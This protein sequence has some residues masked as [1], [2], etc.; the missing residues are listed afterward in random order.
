MREPLPPRPGFWDLFTAVHSPGRRWPGALRAAFVLALPGSVALLLGYDVE[1]LLIA[2]GG[3]TVIYGEGHPLRTRW[4]VMSIAAL[5]LV[6]GSVAGAFVGSVVW[7]QGG[8]WWLLLSALFTASVATVGAFV[9][10]ALRLQPPG[11][12]FIVMVT[13]GATMVARLGLNPFEVGAWACVGAASGLALG[14]LPGRAPER[15]AVDTLEKAVADFAAGDPSVAR[16]HQART[17]LSNAWNMLADA[18]VIRAG[19]VVDTSRADLVTRTLKAHRRLAA[20]NTPGHAAEELTDTPNY[21]DL[22][23][24]AIPHTR[25][26][27]SYRLYRS[28]HR[29]SHAT[30]TAAKVFGA[31]LAAGVLGIAVGFDRPDWAVVSALLILQWGPDR[32]PG[33]IRGLHRLLGSLLGIGLFAALHLLDLNLWGLLL[34]LAV[35][36]F[37]AEVFVVRNYVLCVIFT[38]PLALMMGNSLALPLGETVVSRTAEVSLSVIFA[39]ALLWQGR[40]EPAHHALLMQRCRESVT[41]LLGALLAATPDQALAQR[42]DLQYELL[43][44]RHAAQSLAGNHPDIATARWEEHLV[45]QATGY[46]LL[47]RCNAAPDTP[48]PVGDIRAVAERIS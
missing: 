2:A 16:L 20:L 28:L 36:Q 12:F 39:L 30:M 33:T 7:D 44:E 18:G 3:F 41:T 17:A 5:L 21:V 8:H 47:D 9:Q 43:S 6:T 38:T 15:G 22:N 19:R 34:A 48:V 42:R 23:R 40:N 10:N 32:L 13:G 25:P 27:I 31:C 14:M 35:C 4:R 24:T 1:M 46:A 37:F 11:S 26:S 45:L 29:H